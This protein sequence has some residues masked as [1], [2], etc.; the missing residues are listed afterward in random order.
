M[1]QCNAQ[2][3]HRSKGKESNLEEPEFQDVI[4]YFRTQTSAPDAPQK[5]H[6]PP[7]KPAWYSPSTSIFT[8]CIIIN[9]AWLLS[10]FDHFS[11]TYQAIPIFYPVLWCRYIH[12]SLS[13]SFDSINLSQGHRSWHM[14]VWPSVFSV[15]KFHNTFCPSRFFF[16]PW[17][18]HSFKHRSDPTING[19]NLS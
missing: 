3:L 18:F 15:H 1:A 9:T 14:P 8:I 4:N 17:K 7:D 12:P 11:R 5:S 2:W 6:S 13:F 16:F 19:C 10:S